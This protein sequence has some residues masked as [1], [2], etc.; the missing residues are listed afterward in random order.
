MP[1]GRIHHCVRIRA[2]DL[3]ADGDNTGALVRHHVRHPFGSAPKAGT[4]GS[5]HAP[6]L[7]LCLGHGFPAISRRLRLLHYQHLSADGSH[8][9]NGHRLFGYAADSEC[10]CIHPHLLLLWQSTHSC[11][12]SLIFAILLFD[13][14]CSSFHTYTVRCLIHLLVG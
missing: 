5:D 14:N 10:S 7:D 12:H 4:S 1:S 13:G 6:R 8:E 2:V 3:Y 11:L 9:I